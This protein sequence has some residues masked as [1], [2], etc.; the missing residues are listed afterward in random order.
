ME[1][2]NSNGNIHKEHPERLDS[3][4]VPQMSNQRFSTR[5]DTLRGEYIRCLKSVKARACAS[6]L[7][8]LWKCELVAAVTA[9]RC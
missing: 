2:H 8:L 7:L 6:F 3:R 4:T 1:G 9:C 5:E